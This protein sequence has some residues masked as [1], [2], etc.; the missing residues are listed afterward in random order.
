V[1][2][3]VCDNLQLLLQQRSKRVFDFATLIKIL[4]QKL[5]VLIKEKGFRPSFANKYIIKKSFQN[6]P[7]KTFLLEVETCQ[8]V[9]SKFWPSV[10]KP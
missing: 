3:Y 9:C 6:F 4:S 8:N 2:L 5:T 1:R 7:R 10:A